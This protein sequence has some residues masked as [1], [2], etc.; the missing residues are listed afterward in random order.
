MR[1]FVTGGAGF[2]GS[3]LV[4]QLLEAGYGVVA[5]DNFSTG[6]E[7]F[8]SCASR[9]ARFAM[10][11]GDVLD[12]THLMAAMAGADVVFH[13]AANADVRYGL[14]HPE[15]DLQQNTVATFNVLEAMRATGVQ[16]IAFA[17][18]GSIYGEPTIFPT[19]ESAQFT[20][21][22]AFYGASKLA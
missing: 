13:L 1:A 11:R 20:V 2:I 6:Q 5:Y 12:T 22:T 19:P 7:P 10:V 16:R 3:H 8:L 21:Q 4:D 17:S 18:T 9:N 14:D 15:R